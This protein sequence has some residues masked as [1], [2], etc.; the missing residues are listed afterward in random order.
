MDSKASE[1]TKNQSEEHE[2]ISEQEDPIVRNDS[3]LDA[4]K[5]THEETDEQKWSYAS[6]CTTSFAFDIK[7]PKFDIIVYPYRCIKHITPLVVY[8]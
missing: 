8:W 7:Y 1:S 2:T 5:T 3:N 4:I 6:D